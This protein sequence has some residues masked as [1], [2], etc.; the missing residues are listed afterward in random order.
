MVNAMAVD[1]VVYW[2]ATTRTLE[3]ESVGCD[4][5][6]APIASLRELRERIDA[7]RPG[8]IVLDASQCA[9]CGESAKAS[10]IVAELR[11]RFAALPLIC[12]GVGSVAEAVMLMRSG[13]ADCFGDS[14]KA[15]E[16]AAALQRAI[17]RSRADLAA[18]AERG[19]AAGASPLGMLSPREREVLAL[20]T[21]GWET[22]EIARRLEVTAKTVEFHRSHLLRKVGARNVAQLVRMAVEAGR[23]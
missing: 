9:I 15:W 10:P 2:C 12:L 4:S 6:V 5:A 17:D 7:E 19:Q 18:R 1:A 8:C 11:G 16:I 3:S 23:Q 13:A 22:K 21:E 20:V 14:A